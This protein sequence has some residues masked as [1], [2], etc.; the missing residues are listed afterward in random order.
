MSRSVCSQSRSLTCLGPTHQPIALA[1]F[2]RGL[3]GL[4]FVRPADA[5]EVV[6]AWL[7]AL[8]DVDHP[9]LFALSR[10]PVPLLEGSDRNQVARGAYPVFGDDKPQLTLAATG[11]EVC[12][13]IETAKLIK[14]WRVRV[15]SMPSMEH[16]DRQAVS[17][18]RSVFPPESLIVGIEAYGSLGWTRYAHAGCH[19]H[20]FGMSAPQ[21]T[22]YEYFG[23]EPE[24]LAKKITTW[25][26]RQSGRLP[27]VGEFEELLLGQV[28][29]HHSP[30]PYRE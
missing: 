2:F 15:V 24:N 29:H 20:T 4:N 7:L 10:Q 30:M 11:A 28:P 18:R 8:R 23:F 6:G 5:E 17:Y 3:P 21:S 26:E 9:S 25:A 19:M 13:A 1:H 16:F 22:L 12:R 14:D 27:A